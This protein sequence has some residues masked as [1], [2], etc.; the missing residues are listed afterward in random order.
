MR[1]IFALSVL[2]ALCTSANAAT[3]SPHHFQQRDFIVHS[4]GPTLL[5]GDQP[6]LIGCLSRA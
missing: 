5:A 6:R 3:L 1:F 4:G 2:I